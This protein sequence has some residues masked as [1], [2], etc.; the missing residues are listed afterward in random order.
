[1]KSDKENIRKEK[2]FQKT[3]KSQYV[4]K[5]DKKLGKLLD[6]LAK[7]LKLIICLNFLLF[8]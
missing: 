8:L 5:L 1:M 6:S 2:K 7:Y 4:E 3:L